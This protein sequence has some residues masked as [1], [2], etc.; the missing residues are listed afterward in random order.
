M[1]LG[2]AHTGRSRYL[3]LRAEKLNGDKIFLY[4]PVTM[5]CDCILFNTRL[6]PARRVAAWHGHG[7]SWWPVTAEPW[8][9]LW[10]FHTSRRR[11]EGEREGKKPDLEPERR[12]CGEG[13]WSCVCVRACVRALSIM[14]ELQTCGASEAMMVVIWCI[15]KENVSLVHVTFLRREKTAQFRQYIETVLQINGWGRQFSLL[16][17]EIDSFLN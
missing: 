17:V 12:L 3:R 10:F 8:G 2:L 1:K 15:D 14:W 11:K 6:Q 7:L 4:P 9:S 5:T 16:M 13:R